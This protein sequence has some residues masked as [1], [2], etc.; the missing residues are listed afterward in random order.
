MKK[1][2][3]KQKIKSEVPYYDTKKYRVFMDV[4]TV[5]G[6]ILNC[7]GIY[8]SLLVREDTAE[9]SKFSDKPIYYDILLYKNDES[10]ESQ[11]YDKYL[12][13]YLNLVVDDF[14]VYK[15]GFL[16][17]NYNAVFTK[18]KYY[19]VYDYSLED[20]YY[21][22]MRY[23]LEDKL[24]MQAQFLEEYEVLPTKLNYSFSPNKQFCYILI[25]TETTSEKNLDLVFFEYHDE[26]D[27][28]TLSMIEEDGKNRVDTMRIN[29]DVEICKDY[30]IDLWAEGNSMRQDDLSFMFD[31][32]SDLKEKMGIEY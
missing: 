13:M 11:I 16:D 3:K 12:S 28:F 2:K 5:M 20:K 14:E 25:Y 30:F 6:I 19:M 10:F 9:L 1:K 29:E 7:I 4:L 22:Y 18:I 31:V 15:D 27:T 17:V 21:Q 32:Y 8:I 26:G 23:G 24:E